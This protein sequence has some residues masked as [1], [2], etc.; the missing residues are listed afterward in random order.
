[1][2]NV[3]NIYK[4]KGLTPLQ[5][6]QLVRKK[7]PEYEKEKIGFAGRLDPL[8]HG[9]LLLM[10]G[11]ETTKQKDT[12]LNLPKEYEFEA[13]FGVATDTYDSLGLISVIA[14]AVKQS[15]DGKIA[16]SSSIPRNDKLELE[17]KI[18]AFIQT[19]LGKQTQSYPPYSSKTVH[20][21]PLYLWAKENKLSEIV[22]PTKDIE[23][24]DFQLLGTNKINAEELQTEIVK[25]IDSVK[26]DFRQKE[27]QERWKIFFAKTVPSVT[28]QTARFS[29]SCSS[30]TYVRSLVNE[31]GRRLGTGAITLEILRTKVGEYLLDDSLKLHNEILYNAQQRFV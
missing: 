11:E 27:I 16:S 7:I 18:K 5:T 1:M 22:T 28:F 20:G 25:Q 3:L 19:K 2:K 10:I 31:L 30:G 4:P 23:I 9:V 14:N 26:G 13:V 24:F 8:A 12:F 21:K 6:I 15:P 29:L 17:K